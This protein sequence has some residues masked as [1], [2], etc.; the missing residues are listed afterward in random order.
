M[1]L[2]KTK[3]ITIWPPPRAHISVLVAMGLLLASCTESQL[4]SESANS[5]TIGQ[6]ATTNDSDT[7]AEDSTSTVDTSTE[8]E[9]EG[10][11]SSDPNDSPTTTEAGTETTTTLESANE[12]RSPTG[13]IHC[14]IDLSNARCS[15]RGDTPW[16]VGGAL[17]KWATGLSFGF[18][19]A[20][21]IQGG[22]VGFDVAENGRPEAAC[23]DQMVE[24][25]DITL[26]YG[27]TMT[28]GG[29]TCQSQQFGVTCLNR[30]GN[31]YRL[32]TNE[33]AMLYQRSQ[34]WT[35]DVPSS[36]NQNL[37]F[38]NVEDVPAGTLIRTETESA[39]CYLATF[40]QGDASVN[41]AECRS[42]GNGPNDDWS[43]DQRSCQGADFYG[44]A[45]FTGPETLGTPTFGCT[46]D[47]GPL[48]DPSTSSQV[49]EDGN[50]ARIGDITCG[51]TDGSLACFTDGDGMLVGPN[52]VSF[53][54]QRDV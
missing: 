38:N 17:P 20:G 3:V 42:I 34:D 45:L 12:F 9:S 29:I 52:E 33:I 15:H 47:L 19:E 31:G 18:T 7:A 2:L 46:T 49:F 11:Q 30:D 22:F 4:V 27:D 48:A 26:A 50:A 24:A 13:N 25:A 1:S 44:Y 28:V 21:C 41:S 36:A 35:T 53:F 14:R 54:Y 37:R 51:N 10:E 32:A 23:G 43:P 16:K 8:P 5:T 6:V 39:K 40:Q